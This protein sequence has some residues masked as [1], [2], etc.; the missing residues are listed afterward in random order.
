MWRT[1]NVCGAWPMRRQ[2]Y[3]YLPS[4]KASSPSGWYQIILL[5]DRG[6]RVLTRV[7]LDSGEARIRTHYLFIA[8]PVCGPREKSDRCWIWILRRLPSST[9]KQPPTR[10]TR[11]RGGGSWEYGVS[12]VPGRGITG[13]ARKKKQLVAYT[14]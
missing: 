11:V 3:G 12:S 5:G 9:T 10:W 7:A 2:T 4:R 1:T 13:F 8:S 6:T 14:H